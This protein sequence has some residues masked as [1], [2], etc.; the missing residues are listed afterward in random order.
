MKNEKGSALIS[1][2]LVVLVLTMVGVASLFFMTT[3]ERLTNVSRL[4]R[5]AFYAAET[6]L[7]AAES[8]IDTQ[9]KNNSG[10]YSVLLAFPQTADN[11]L[12]V[13]QGG[14]IHPTAVVLSDPAIVAGNIDPLT[15][16]AM[17]AQEMRSILIPTGEEG[18]TLMYSVYVRNDDDE[19]S[20]TV[21]NN[22]RVN[23][24]SVGTL[25]TG[26]GTVFQKTLEEQMGPLGGGGAIS[27]QKDQNMGGTGGLNTGTGS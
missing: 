6:G 3:E 18:Y 17:P 23:I 19:M 20:N 26:S 8:S 12:T 25:I 5:A 9:Y 2:I 21:D 7:R 16:A 24:V 13:P 15:G 14:T 11:V 1:V 4:E 10:I 22:Q 27:G